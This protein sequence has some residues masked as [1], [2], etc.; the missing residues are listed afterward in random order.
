MDSRAWDDRY[1]ATELV[2][3]AE[4]NRFLVAETQDLEPGRVLD[5]A[6][7]EGRNGIW[8]AERGWE[9]TGVD[10]SEVAIGKARAIAESRNVFAEWVA[11]DLLEWEPEVDAFDL[12]LAFYLQVP[13]HE[14]T[15]ILA[16]AKK[17]LSPGGT[18]LLVGHDLRNISEG[19][20][21]PQD[22][23]VLYTPDDITADLAGLH[24]E[25][26]ATVD[27]DGA[28]DALVRARRPAA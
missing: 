19:R 9:L 27:R 1:A 8:L 23:R 25:K 7:G 4:P 14:R 15:R 3:S 13:A 11:A 26:A 5:L 6:C 12:V 28:L 22:P 2:W 18:F 17:S 16:K 20:G 24:I 21:G 10:F